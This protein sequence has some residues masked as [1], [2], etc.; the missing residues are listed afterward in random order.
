MPVPGAF[1]CIVAA[2][3]AVAAMPAVTE[4]MHRHHRTRDHE[5]NPVLRKPFDA[6]TPSVKKIGW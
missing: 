4:E 1:A 5:E 2:P 6:S 3:A